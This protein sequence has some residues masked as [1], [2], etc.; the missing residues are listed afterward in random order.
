ML[1]GPVLA[2]SAAIAWLD[3]G[4]TLSASWLLD[5]GGT[6]PLLGVGLDHDVVWARRAGEAL[7]VLDAQGTLLRVSVGASLNRLEA[8]V[9]VSLDPGTRGFELVVGGLVS[10]TADTLAFTPVSG[11]P[12]ALSPGIPSQ[13][14]TLAH[15]VDHV[16]IDRFSEVGAAPIKIL[17]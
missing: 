11:S 1:S 4:R 12:G 13:V 10:W 5:D 3:H 16:A 17:G 7:L 15:G 8:E 9:I 2:S 6:Q 14:A